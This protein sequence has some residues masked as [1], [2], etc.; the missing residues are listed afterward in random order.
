MHENLHRAGI[1]G[2]ECLAILLGVLLVSWLG[3]GAD[4]L[5]SLLLLLNRFHLLLVCLFSGLIVYPVAKYVVRNEGRENGLWFLP[6]FLSCTLVLLWII[7][8]LQ[9]HVSVIYH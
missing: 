3:L 5:L 9:S 7:V 4:L 8:Q 1:V 2:L 6:Y